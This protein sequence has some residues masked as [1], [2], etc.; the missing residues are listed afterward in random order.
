ME[1]RGDTDQ[2]GHQ[3]GGNRLREEGQRKEAPELET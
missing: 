1:D 3:G 2:D